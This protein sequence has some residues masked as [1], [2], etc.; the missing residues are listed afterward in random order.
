MKKTAFIFPGQGA[1][2]V[3]MGKDIYENFKSAKRIFDVASSITGIDLVSLCFQ[4]PKEQLSDTV[5]CQVAIYTVSIACLDALKHRLKTAKVNMPDLSAVAGLSL[6][7]YTALVCAGCL[8]FEEGVKLVYKR[9]LFMKEAAEN[10]RGT[11]ASV[12]GLTEREVQQICRSASTQ[13]ANLNSPGQIVIAGSPENIKKAVKLV[14]EYDK[15]KAIPLKVSGAYH[16]SFMDSAKTKLAEYINKIN[17]NPPNNLF[18]SNV[19]GLYHILPEDIKNN[20]IKQVNSSVYW[21][22]TVELMMDTGITS[23]VEVGPG[24]VLSGLARRIEPSLETNNIETSSDI[25]EWINTL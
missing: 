4:G 6:G 17:F 10:N 15:A 2:Y 18:I 14:K 19:T 24:K 1:Q 23:F 7:E 8:T 9:G 11:M 3:G 22:K 21:Q 12:L 16:S 25:T 20:L 5:F 13:I